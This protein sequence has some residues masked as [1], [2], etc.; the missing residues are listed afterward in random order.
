MAGDAGQR[1]VYVDLDGERIATLL[2][3]QS[4]SVEIAP[5]PH[6]VK[7]NNTLVSKTLEFT[8]TAGETVHYHFANRPG[9]FGLPFLA[10]MGVAPLFLSVERVSGAEP[11]TFS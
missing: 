6:R 9:R 7:L 11:S 5:G 10:L 4:V 8:A 2:D 3:R 1:Q